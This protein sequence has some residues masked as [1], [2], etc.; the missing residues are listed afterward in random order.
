MSWLQSNFPSHKPELWEQFPTALRRQASYRMQSLFSPAQLKPLREVVFDRN[1]KIRIS[2]EDMIG[3]SIYLYGLYEY[4]VTRFMKAYLQPGMKFVDIGANRG[5]YTLLAVK[6][7]GAS[8]KVT[9]FEPVPE[10][11]EELECNVALNGF[12]NV[13]PQRLV[14][15]DHPGDVDFFI[16]RSSVNTGL[17][18]LVAPVTA[19]AEIE[20]RRMV[21][22]TLDRYFL[23]E[24]RPL[25]DLLKVDVE[26]AEAQ[27]FKG[28]EGVFS[29]PEAPDLV[30]ELSSD[31]LPREQ[32][33]QA[34][35]TLY[36]L[37]LRSDGR[38]ALSPYDS[39][40]PKVYYRPYEPQNL[41]ATKALKDRL[42]S[43]LF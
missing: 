24:K 42:R 17:S 19:S 27:V 1:L 23:L 18:S 33:R 2:L 16:N 5:Y 9:A 32:L 34:G 10:L 43:Y 30:F 28:G 14:L 13:D 20:K 22:T 25:P 41:F 26:G 12:L 11:F 36:D 29:L 21:A 39:E 35:Y 8:G 31:A 37:G 40:H 6:R 15:S 38:M 3:L 7:V 4:A